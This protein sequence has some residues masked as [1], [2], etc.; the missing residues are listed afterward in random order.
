MTTDDLNRTPPPLSSAVESL[1]EYERLIEET[2]AIVRARV[3][4]R[5]REAMRDGSVIAFRSRRPTPLLRVL[6]AAAAA[7]VMMASVA[8]AYQML[9]RSVPPKSGAA[10]HHGAPIVLAP[11]PDPATVPSMAPAAGGTTKAGAGK[12]LASADGS[13][14]SGRPGA[15]E[16]RLLDRARQSDARGDFTS[17]LSASSEHE[18]HYPDGRLAEERE[19]LRVKALIGLGRHHEARQL[20]AKFRRQ[21]PRSVLLPRLQ[22]MLASSR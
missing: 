8:A 7:L 1:V 9:R 4:A 19:I 15:E 3:L 12:L 17:V 21:F 14:R 13:R 18:R 20:A 10:R 2:P 5:A 6:F 11:V 22:E 16:L